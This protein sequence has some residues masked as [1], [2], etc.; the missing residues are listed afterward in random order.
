MR[1]EPDD[2][3]HDLRGDIQHHPSSLLIKGGTSLIIKILQIDK[4]G[5][6]NITQK[7]FSLFLLLDPIFL[8]DPM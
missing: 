2:E 5:L 3:V 6:D 8:L 4:I 7:F 1:V